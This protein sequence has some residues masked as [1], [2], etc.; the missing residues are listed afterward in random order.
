MP[1]K[2]LSDLRDSVRNALPRHALEIYLAAFNNAWE[3]YKDPEDRREQASREETAHRVAWSAVKQAYE[4]R[5]NEWVRR[6][7]E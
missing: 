7:K 6:G 5:W 4:K 3:N 2:E 1:Y